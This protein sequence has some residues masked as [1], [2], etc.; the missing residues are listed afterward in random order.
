MSRNRPLALLVSLVATLAATMGVAALT[1]GAAY[2]TPS[3]TTMKYPPAPAK[4]VV[5]KGTVKVGVTVHAT[6]RKY[7]AKEK[8]Y[9][10]VTFT[11]KG[12]HKSKVV[13]TAYITAD[14]N[15]KLSLNVRMAGA[16]TVVIKGVGAKSHSSASATIHVINKQKGNGGWVIKPA[17]FSTPLTGGAPAITSIQPIP[18][19]GAGVLL[20]GLSVMALAGSAVVTRQT[21]RR[22][23]RV[24]AAA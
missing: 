10:T 1:P 4:M 24:G 23:R 16:G 17:A 20:A 6:G 2:A 7:K 12:S 8:V 9:V 14:K 21:V 13:K 5:N 11:P 19:G 15:G 18:A 3:V 22:R